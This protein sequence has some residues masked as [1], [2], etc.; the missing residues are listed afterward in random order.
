MSWHEVGRGG[1]GVV[2]RVEK[3]HVHGLG[4]KFDDCLGARRGQGLRNVTV[5][6]HVIEEMLS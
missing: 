2:G 3:E 5:R 1:R 4:L 6:G